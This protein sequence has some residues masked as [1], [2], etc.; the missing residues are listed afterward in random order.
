[1]RLLL[2]PRENADGVSARHFCATGASKSVDRIR[3]A[4]SV[5]RNCDPPVVGV[6]RA[7]IRQGDGKEFNYE[8]ARAM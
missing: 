6:A 5:G 3:V 7:A 1:M 8:A 4:A 2:N